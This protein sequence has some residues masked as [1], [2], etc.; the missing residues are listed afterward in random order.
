MKELNRTKPFGCVSGDLETAPSARFV[1]DGCYFNAHG[2]YL[3]DC[4]G[5]VYEEKATT[6]APS[7]RGEVADVLS[8]NRESIQQAIV[9][10]VDD[11]LDALLVRERA[12]KN[13][14]GVI[15]DLEDEIRIRE[16]ELSG[17]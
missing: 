2:S 3:C 16:D 8:G 6:Q 11:D 17:D 12:T 4:D 1:Q 5:K 9:D 7:T 13:R 14:K 15:T 10:M